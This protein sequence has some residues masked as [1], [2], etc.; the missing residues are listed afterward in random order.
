ME[1]G[2]SYSRDPDYMGHGFG[3]TAAAAA[4]ASEYQQLPMAQ[5][6]S[7]PHPTE[8]QDESLCNGTHGGGDVQRTTFP[9][10]HHGTSQQ[11]HSDRDGK[12]TMPTRGRDLVLWVVMQGMLR[13][14]IALLSPRV[15]PAKHSLLLFRPPGWLPGRTEVP[16]QDESYHH[17]NHN[18]NHNHSH[19]HPPHHHHA[20]AK[21]AEDTDCD[22]AA[23][24]ALLPN[25]HALRA[26]QS[27][28]APLRRASD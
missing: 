9:R 13:M 17:H 4:A 11:I 10:N 21:P 6:P 19:H 28:S 26:S 2:N 5:H 23:M 12:K 24:Q 18:H 20:L 3:P 14:Q 16:A 15:H 25:G 8:R 27:E 22:T 1:N 7:H